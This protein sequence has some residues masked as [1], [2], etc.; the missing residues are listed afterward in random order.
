MKFHDLYIKLKVTPSE[1][2]SVD[3]NILK[4]AFGGRKKKL[5]DMNKTFMHK[6]WKSN[7]N[8]SYGLST[9]LQ[10]LYFHVKL[11]FFLQSLFLS[12]ESY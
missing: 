3:L 5:V 8:K 11:V 2:S 12:S 7:M 1:M 4:L 6:Y 10:W 9:F